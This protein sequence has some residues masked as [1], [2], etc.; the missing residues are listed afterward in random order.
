VKKITVSF[1]FGPFRMAS[2]TCQTKYW[3]ARMFVGGC[4]SFS[5]GPVSVGSTNDT[6][7]SVPAAAS[8]KNVAMWTAFVLKSRKIQDVGRLP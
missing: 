7:G 2:I 6:A 1:Q 8:A 4:S 5:F 3:P